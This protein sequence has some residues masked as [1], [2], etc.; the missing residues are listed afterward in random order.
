MGLVTRFEDLE[1]WQ[2][3]RK[4]TAD[5]YLVADGSALSRDFVL[6][7][8]IRR[9]AISTMNN[10]AEGFDSASR[11]E[12]RRF[13]RY[14]GRS[15]SEVKRDGGGHVRGDAAAYGSAKTGS[16][17]HRLTGSPAARTLL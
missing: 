2:Q 15:A 16:P 1:V 5:V 8:Q 11:F 12:F 6:G 13:L 7:D 17:A 14:A 9:A 10:I 3:A 4:L